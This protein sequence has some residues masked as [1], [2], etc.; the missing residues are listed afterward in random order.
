[1]FDGHIHIRPGEVKREAFLARLRESNLQGGLL[2]SIGPS[3]PE[4]EPSHQMDF[5]QRLENL[6][7]WTE[8][9]ED[10]YPFF[11]IDPLEQNA[12]QQ[13]ER[14]CRAG[15]T[16][17][18][19]VC[20]TYYPKESDVMEIMGQIAEMGKPIL[21]HSGILW[22]GRD[23]AKYNRPANWECLLEIKNLRFSLAHA[24]WPW[25]DECIAVYGKFLNAYTTLSE[26]SEM[27]IDLTPGTP[28]IYRKDLLTKLLTV[29]Y[30]VQNNIIFGTDCSVNDYNVSWVREWMERD[31]QIYAE[32]GMDS[33]FLE[34][35]YRNNLE[36]FLGVSRREIS[37]QSLKPAE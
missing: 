4:G 34:K 11:W 30:D 16:G 26:C 10:L 23:S 13:V 5:E 19:I 1:M 8:G 12:D 29:G 24:A 35:V 3:V 2:I 18:K 25:H 17:F 21:F 27:F 22:D 20:D 37:Y 14:A 36:N 32:L 15:V 7:E 9:D 31:N 6:F 28:P 33:R